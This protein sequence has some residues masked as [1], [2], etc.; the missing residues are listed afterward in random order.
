MQ[1]LSARLGTIALCLV[2]LGVVLSG[3]TSIPSQETGSVRISSVPPGAEVYFDHEYHG[4]TPSLISAVPAGNHTVEI[5]K[6]GYEH[7]SGPVIV[8]RGTV[9]NISATLLSIPIIQPV[10]FATE[11]T[12]VANKNLPR[13]HVD[14]YWTYPQATTSSPANPAQLLIH[15]DGFNVGYADAREV[16]VS[17]NLYYEGRQICWNTVYLGTLTAG[18]HVTKDTMVSCTLPSNLNP[19]DVT[20]RFENVVVTP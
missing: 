14:G 7:W 16:T 20:I 8:T 11:T 5:R 3:C 2:V 18:G 12:P 19:S 4:T 13:I 15:A 1:P 6:S 10:V 17:A 9:A